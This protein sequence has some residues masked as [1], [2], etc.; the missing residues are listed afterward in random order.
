MTNGESHG[1]LILPRWILKD[2]VTED[3]MRAVASR[4][5]GEVAPEIVFVG[6]PFAIGDRVALQPHLD[7]WMRGIRYGT[8][9]GHQIGRKGNDMWNVYTDGGPAVLLGND[10]LRAV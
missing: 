4:I 7:L 8:I 3:D 1:R 10:D 2:G 9:M 5:F 6:P